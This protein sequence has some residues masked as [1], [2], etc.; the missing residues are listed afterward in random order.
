MVDKNVTPVQHSPRR[1]PVA[2]QKDVKKKIIELQE[3]GIIKKA[4]EPSEWISNMVVVAKPS[5]IRICLDSKDLNKAVH[6]PKF[7]MPT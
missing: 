5:K 1:V 7:Q 3:K 4:D 6:H 2:L